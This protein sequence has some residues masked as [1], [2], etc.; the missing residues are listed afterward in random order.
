MSSMSSLSPIWSI[1]STSSIFLGF[2]S[3]GGSRYSNTRGLLNLEKA[4]LSTTNI[5]ITGGIQRGLF[6]HGKVGK[7]SSTNIRIGGI[8]SSLASGL[9]MGE[10]FPPEIGIFIILSLESTPFKCSRSTLVQRL[11]LVYT[12]R[13]VFK[14]HPLTLTT[15]RGDAVHLFKQSPGGLGEIGSQ[16]IGAALLRF[17][18]MLF[19]SFLVRDSGHFE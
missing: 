13:V 8:C 14:V 7:L 15:L 5:R 12:F 1:S 11:E 17:A 9:L 19:L 2:R 16:K 10:N 6:I 18:S 4:V 3:T